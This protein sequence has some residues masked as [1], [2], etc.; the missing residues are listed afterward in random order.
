[1]KKLFYKLPFYIRFHLV[2]A[3][4]SFIA[5]SLYRI[6]FF[7][8]YSYR[9]KEGT[10]F[11]ILK[12]FVLGIRYCRDLYFAWVYARYLLYSLFKSVSYCSIYLEKFSFFFY[13][14]FAFS[15]NCRCYLLRK[16]KQTLG[17]RGICLPWI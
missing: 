5:L 14:S 9:I 8:V 16:W 2:I 13:H 17:I 4:T 7:F 12:A 6:T 15:I 11:L 1:M 3:L 10:P